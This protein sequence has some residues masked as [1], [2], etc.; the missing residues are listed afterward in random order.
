MIPPPDLTSGKPVEEKETV[1]SSTSPTDTEG[2][3][4]GNNIEQ[5][6]KKVSSTEPPSSLSYSVDV[7]SA[8]PREYSTNSV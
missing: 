5:I 8:E 3:L 7:E 2:S 6:T 1:Q 4:V